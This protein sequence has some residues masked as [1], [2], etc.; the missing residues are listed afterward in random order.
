[1]KLASYPGSRYGYEATVKLEWQFGIIRSFAFT[2]DLIP[3]P[4]QFRLLSIGTTEFVCTKEKETARALCLKVCMPRS[5]CSAWDHQHMAL[6][7][8]LIN[9]VNEKV[10]SLSK[11][12]KHTF[13]LLVYQE[14]RPLPRGQGQAKGCKYEEEGGSGKSSWRNC[15]F[16]SCNFQF[17]I[18]ISHPIKLQLQV[19][20]LISDC[21]LHLAL[22]QPEA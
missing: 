1:M 18:T 4:P 12:L 15:I 5:T 17:K 9:G 14:L 11:L 6:W 3:R 20:I 13:N 19:W 16:N 8:H 2:N 21:P 22:L 7:A 10:K